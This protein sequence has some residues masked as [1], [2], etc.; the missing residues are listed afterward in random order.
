VAIGQAVV[1]YGLGMPLLVALRRSGLA[2]R[3]GWRA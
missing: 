3:F 2:E 1:V